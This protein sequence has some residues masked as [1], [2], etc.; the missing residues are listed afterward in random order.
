MDKK[1]VLTFIFGIISL[2]AFLFF[3]FFWNNH[4]GLSLSFLPYL[5]GAFAFVF[6]LSALNFLYLFA[7]KRG[8]L[9]FSGLVGILAA[10]LER[11]F[12]PFS[13][14]AGIFLVFGLVRGYSSFQNNREAYRKF[15]IRNILQ[16]R[17]SFYV[18]AL[19]LALLAIGN[20][21]AKND[22]FRITI[23]EEI[24]PHMARFSASL[25]NPTGGIE[26]SVTIDLAEKAFDEQI[27][28]LR[29]ELSKSGIDDEAFV[30]QQIEAARKSYLAQV[31]QGINSNDFGKEL[32]EKQ[33]RDAKG[34]VEKELNKFLSDYVIYLPYLIGLTFFLSISFF[35]PAI[36]VGSDLLFLIVF[37]LLQF[38]KVISVRTR[39]E[40]IEYLEI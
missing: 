25:I 17:T 18:L 35:A 22:A 15:A 19:S 36:V 30:R 1:T 12:V 6:L 28:R 2:T 3:W 23:P 37:K 38:L 33:L 27:P 29:S 10:Y 34:L 31:R 9:M 14:L 7:P 32:I 8:F 13:Y 16:T 5:P 26:K 21:S 4:L 20:S 40:E 39:N 24:I 11:K